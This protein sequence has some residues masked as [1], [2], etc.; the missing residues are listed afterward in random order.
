[1]ADIELVEYLWHHHQFDGSEFMVS[2]G[3]TKRTATRVY[4][5]DRYGRVGFVDRQ[6]L[7]CEGSAWHR[8]TQTRLYAEKPLTDAERRRQYA[9][10]N[11][12][13]LRAEMADT[14]PDRGGD[15]AAFIQA[16]QRYQ[17]A[18]SVVRHG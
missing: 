15:S 12:S 6:Q 8:P 17:R 2:Y 5:V 18:V 7:E 3:I 13:R 11:V 14:H 9:A 4:F 10:E 16:H 1:M